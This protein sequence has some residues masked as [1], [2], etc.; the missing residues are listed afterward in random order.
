MFTVSVSSSSFF[1][2]ILASYIKQYD[3]SVI[4]NKDKNTN[5][6]R[7]ALYRQIGVFNLDMSGCEQFV[8]CEGPN[9]IALQVWTLQETK[10]TYE[11]VSK[12]LF[13]FVK[14]LI[15]RYSLKISFE[16]AFKCNNGDFTVNLKGMHDLL[17]PEYR[18]LEH[19]ENHASDHLVKPWNLGDEL[20]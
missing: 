7:H 5:T 13:E 2:H 18:C 1:N 20:K 3:V 15:K 4:L 16:K 8:V 14:E 11:S 9:I 17:K 10:N 6:E 12:E 19:M